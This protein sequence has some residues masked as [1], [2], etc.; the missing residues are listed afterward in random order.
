MA[1]QH[2]RVRARGMAVGAAAVVVSAALA[3]GP[4][5]GAVRTDDLRP[6]AP[7]PDGPVVTPTVPTA[8]VVPVT[9]AVPAPLPRQSGR[10]WLPLRRG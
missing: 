2:R 4:A 9:P 7:A 3:A 5:A 8:P 6:A 10:S 1:P